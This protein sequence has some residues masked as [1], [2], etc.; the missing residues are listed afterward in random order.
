[1]ENGLR[2]PRGSEDSGGGATEQAADWALD[3]GA[4]I[5]LS[6]L[7][8]YTRSKKSPFGTF[9]MP[10]QVSGSRVH[11]PLPPE[12]PRDSMATIRLA[13]KSKYFGAEPKNLIAI[14]RGGMGV[15]KLIPGPLDSYWVDLS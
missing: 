14:N 6:G 12:L 15:Y 4:L 2:F 8:N 1:M 5:K 13:I 10:L 11:V 7:T 9:E 3:V